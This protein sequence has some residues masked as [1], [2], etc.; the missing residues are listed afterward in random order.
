MLQ[1]DLLILHQH[2]I[3]VVLLLL[4]LHG[5]KKQMLLQHKLLL[6]VQVIT[7]KLLL[8][9]LHVMLV[10]EELYIVLEV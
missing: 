8:E 3:L 6:F 10:M 7:L 5:L 9:L 4:E 2:L 1:E